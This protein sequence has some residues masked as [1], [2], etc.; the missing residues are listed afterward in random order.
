MNYLIRRILGAIPLLIALSI[1][2]FALIQ[3]PPGD[4]ADQLQ[5]QAMS[6]GGLSREDA[7]A[8]ADSYRE[9]YGLDQP[10]F[11]QY[12]NWMKGMLLHGDFGYS[13]SQNKPI[14]ELV[15]ERLPITLFIA[16]LSHV[17]ATF[18]GAGLGIYAATRQYKLGDTLSGLISFIGMTTPR[19][20][21][22][23]VLLYWLVFGVGLSDVSSLFSPDFILEPW[24]LAK[25][26]NL[27]VHIWP[28]LLIAVFGGMAYNLRVM[29]SNML[30]VL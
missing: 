23:L 7:Q 22:A 28:V 13:F 14:S 11:V 21:M 30:D 17:L 19:F 3:L 25:F 8:M 18:I 1:I 26:W 24:S 15:V 16:G 27:M 5:S 10:M 20:I 9:R 12:I 6:Q 4:Y 2:S 29:R